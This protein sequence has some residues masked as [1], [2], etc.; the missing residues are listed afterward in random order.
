MQNRLF[1]ATN[2]KPPTGRGKQFGIDFNPNHPH[3]LRFGEIRLNV[4]EQDGDR[5]GLRLAKVLSKAVQDGK[6]R[7]TLYPERL[8]RK[9]HLLGSQTLFKKL[10]RLMDGGRQTLVFIHG[11]NVSFAEAIGSALALQIKLNAEGLALDVVTF[12][13]PSDG[14]NTPP[15]AYWNDR[16]DAIASGLAFSRGFQMLHEFFTGLSRQEH[17]GQAVNLLVA[18][19]VDDTALESERKLQRLPEICRRVNVYYNR[20]DLALGLANWIKGQPDRLGESGPKHPLAVPSGVVNVDCSEVVHGIREHSYHLGPALPDIAQ[21]LRG[22]RE[23]QIPK[24]TYLP[25]ANAYLLN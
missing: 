25:S 19:D 23:D 6:H 4:S 20:G 14:K 9:P 5:K 16:D 22:T 18:A 24:R 12:T 10:K 11:F 17:C 3:D 21:V 1:F 15:R 7:L 8:G 2:R 13:W